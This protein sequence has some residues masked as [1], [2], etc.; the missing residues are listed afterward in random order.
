[1]KPI[2][3]NSEKDLAPIPFSIVLRHSAKEMKNAGGAYLTSDL[4]PNLDFIKK[5]GD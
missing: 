1:M 3:F 4:V 5:L 2:P